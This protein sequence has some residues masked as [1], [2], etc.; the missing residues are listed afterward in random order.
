MFATGNKK[1]LNMLILEILRQ[2]TD[3]NH[4]LTQQEIIKLLK[5]NYDMPC[6]RRSVKANV[7]SLKEFGYDIDMEDGYRLLT[8]EFDD[9]ELRILIDSVLFSKVISTKQAKDLIDKIQRLASNFFNAKVSH[10]SNLPELN[11]TINKQAMYGLD[12]L[13][14]AI[15]AKHQVSFMY[16][17]IGTDFKLHPRWNMHYIVNPYQIVANNGRFYLICNYDKYD[18]VSHFRIDKMTDVKELDTKVKPMKYVEGLEHGLNLPKHMA[19][20]LYM[21]SG[22]TVPVKLE[23]TVEVFTD[24]VDWFG[25]DVKVIEEDGDKLVVRVIC[26][27][28]AMRYWA[29]QYGTSVEVLEP[30]SLRNQIISDIKD[31]MKRYKK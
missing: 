25:T 4:S 5:K 6:D 8:R 12:T 31:M 23:T 7:L 29:M 28:E 13:N 10:V 14:D 11:R 1:M 22:P 17:D 18:T 24:I 27:E 3:E 20:H 26:N 21:F 15:A 16:N 9:A 19:E 2:Y 30:E